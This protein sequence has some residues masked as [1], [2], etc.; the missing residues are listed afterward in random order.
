MVTSETK[1]ERLHMAVLALLLADVVGR[2]VGTTVADDAA[3]V[4]GARVGACVGFACGAGV[5]TTSVGPV[6]A[7]GTVDA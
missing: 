4:V 1:V 2:V 3:P 6:L 7:L 5:P